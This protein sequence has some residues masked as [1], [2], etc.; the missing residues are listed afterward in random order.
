[1]TVSTLPRARSFHDEIETTI[2]ESDPADL[3]GNLFDMHER[4][5]QPLRQQIR[6]LTVEATTAHTEH[7]RAYHMLGQAEGLAATVT[8]QVS[9]HAAV[10]SQQSEILAKVRKLAQQSFDGR[11]LAEDLA[12]LLT[13]EIPKPSLHQ[14]PL[15]FTASEQFRAGVFTTSDRA[16]SITLT[17]VGWTNVARYV[18]GGITTEP[19]FLVAD[20]GAVPASTIEAERG[21]VLQMPLLPPLTAVA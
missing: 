21:M 15:S 1:M 18:G 10:I 7:R 6:A 2:R 13:T 4:Q 5:M 12:V 16:V 11:V 9:R 17:F 8:Q 3:A 20:R 14:I 19:T